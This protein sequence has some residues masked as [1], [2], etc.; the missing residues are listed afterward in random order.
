M[1]GDSEQPTRPSKVKDLE[2]WPVG[3]MIKIAAG[4]YTLAA[5]N[6]NGDLYCWGSPPRHFQI[7]DELGGTPNLTEVDGGKEVVDVAIAHSH[8]IVL[9]KEGEVYGIG[10]NRNGQLGHGEIE[11]LPSWTKLHVPLMTAY[12][13]MRIAAG[14]MW[15]FVIIERQ[16]DDEPRDS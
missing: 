8:M 10:S 7:L 13:T 4:G 14:P 11:R 2:G 6:E 5:L 15:S 16:R 9:T 12:R 3:P 1:E